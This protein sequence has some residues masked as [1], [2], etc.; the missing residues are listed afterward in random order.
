MSIAHLSGVDI[1][2]YAAAHTRKW[3]C[4]RSGGAL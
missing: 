1:S 3:R 4:D 2:V